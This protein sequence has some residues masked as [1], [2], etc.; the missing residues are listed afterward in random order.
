[1]KEREKTEGKVQNYHYEQDIV[2]I[3]QT[4]IR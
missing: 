1:M 4:D 3:K 2:K